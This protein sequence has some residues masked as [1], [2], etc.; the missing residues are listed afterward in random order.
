MSQEE[1]GSKYS[2]SKGKD[3]CLIPVNARIVRSIETETGS[4]MYLG[5][6]LLEVCLIGHIIDIKEEESL[7]RLKVWDPSGTTDVCVYNREVLDDIQVE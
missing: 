4:S 5:V 7:I 2:E 3:Q 6:K 1:S